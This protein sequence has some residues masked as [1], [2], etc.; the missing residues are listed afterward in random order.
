MCI[1]AINLHIQAHFD[2]ARREIQ[3]ILPMSPGTSKMFLQALQL[4]I[5]HSMSGVL[6][7]GPSL[8]HWKMSGKMLR[9]IYDTTGN[10]VVAPI[11]WEDFW[12]TSPDVS[13]MIMDLG[14]ALHSL[15]HLLGSLAPSKEMLVSELSKESTVSKNWANWE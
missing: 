7:Y 11:P 2:L 13:P 9:G 4:F 15:L 8:A 1:Y 14:K 5:S 6:D 10:F 3:R 12:L